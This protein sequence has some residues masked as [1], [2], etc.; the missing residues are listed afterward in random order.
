MQVG[1]NASLQTRYVTLLVNTPVSPTPTTYRYFEGV[2][3]DKDKQGELF[4][5]KNIFTLHEKTLATKTAVRGHAL[6][7]DTPWLTLAQI[8]KAIISDFNWALANIEAKKKRSAADSDGQTDK[9][10]LKDDVR[11]DFRSSTVNRDRRLL[12]TGPGLARA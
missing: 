1:Y 4:G 6:V 8:E 12:S 11:A 5:I 9:P 10:S 2:Q 7:C 3:G